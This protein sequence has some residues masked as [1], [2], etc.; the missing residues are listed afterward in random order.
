MSAP[1]GTDA[2]T[3]DGRDPKK[4]N[5]MSTVSD[6]EKQRVALER[7]TVRSL[8]EDAVTLLV[9]AW[10]HG[11]PSAKMAIADRA[12]S[13]GLDL[14]AVDD[15]GRQVRLRVAYDKACGSKETI[16]HQVLGLREAASRPRVPWRSFTLWVVVAMWSLLVAAWLHLHDVHVL[17]KRLAR[18][19][20]LH[21]EDLP[22]SKEFL[23]W[24]TAGI[25]GTNLLEAIACAIFLRRSFR[26]SKVATVQWFFMILFG[27]YP[28]ASRVVELKQARSHSSYNVPPLRKKVT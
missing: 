20:G 17:E 24:V 27:G 21:K 28:I 4:K 3:T 14:R 12:D 1:R 16:K 15:M 19:V 11:C 9:L 6:E 26:F 10:R 8:N 5:K 23:F 25:L 2:Q 13:V 18:L 22:S 7:W